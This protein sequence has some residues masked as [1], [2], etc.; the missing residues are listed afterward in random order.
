MRAP[1]IATIG[2]L[3]IGLLGLGRPLTSVA[4][5]TFETYTDR[6]AFEDRL[7]GP[8]AVRVV[9]FDDIDTS[10]ADPVSFPSNRYRS[11]QG[12]WITGENG[13][14]VSRDFGYPTDFEP[15]SPPNLYAPG[16]NE[17]FVYFYTGFQSARVAGVGVVF[18]DADY[19]GD[20][21]SSMLVRDGF[22]LQ[23]STGT[24]SGGNLSRLFR[25]IVAIDSATN[26]PTPIIFEARITNGNGWP[27]IDENEGVGLD[28][29]V[30][31][32]PVSYGNVGEVC[33]NCIDD[34]HDG[35]IDRLDGECEP[36]AEGGG[37]G[38]GHPTLGKMMVKCQ[39]A[40]A[41]AGAAFVLGVEKQLQRCTDAVLE[42]LQTKP[43]DPGCRTKAEAK[44]AK[45]QATIDR[46]EEKAGTAMGKSC[47]DIPD[48]VTFP[49]EGFGFEA[50]VAECERYGV[51][52]DD[53]EDVGE[54]ILRQHRCRAQQLVSRENARAL[55]LA[56]LGGLD[57]DHDFPCIEPG[58]NGNEHGL[59]DPARAKAAFK[60]Q[61]AIA[62]AGAKYA[63]ARQALTAKCLDA[64]NV[65][66][67]MDANDPDCLSKA[68]AKCLKPGEAVYG[69][70]DDPKTP[71]GKTKNAIVKG[72]KNL[73]PLDLL[74][75]EGLGQGELA[76]QCQGI[77]VP[78][79]DSSADVADCVIAFHACRADRLIE[80]QYPRAFELREI[81]F[82]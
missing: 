57:V 61:Q 72:C 25:G 1:R 77:G 32:T 21:P 26:Q 13:Q 52:L 70:A 16:Q 58:A 45:A 63:S 18:V 55:E 51:I 12:V 20:G 27:G 10:T 9:D 41:K 14:F 33:D 22:G 56:K 42:C 68:Q 6:D 11:S 74:A 78:M 66:I 69:S 67:Q 36:P 60:C 37:A 19:P 8:G 82:D 54:C 30:F 80:K 44:C 79:F 50:E 39:K 59:D 64:V 17:S 81:G 35:N 4:H 29:L 43:N 49:V 28:D 46:L 73:P 53:G 31:A 5:V 34:D 76:A 23:Y 38:V 7:G 71:A 24:V 15:S 47:S 65:C 2:T 40:S 48:Q 75:P 3:L 62:K